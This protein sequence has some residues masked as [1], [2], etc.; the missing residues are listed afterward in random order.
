MMNEE[1]FE[2]A[3][4]YKR[5]SECSELKHIDEFYFKNKARGWKESKCSKCKNKIRSE[6]YQ[7]A[8]QGKKKKHFIDKLTEEQRQ[9]LIDNYNLSSL[10]TLAEMLGLKY[11]VLIYQH[12]KG[13]LLPILAMRQQKENEEKASADKREINP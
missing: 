2:L 6:Y 5:C 13:N 10:R 3:H 9:M 4:K 7:K 8:K 11:H 12:N 1:L